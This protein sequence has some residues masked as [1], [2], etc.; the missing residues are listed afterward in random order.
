MLALSKL[1]RAHALK[2]VKVFIN[3]ALAVRTVL[4]RFSERAAGGSHCF[5][6]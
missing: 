5:G 1:T 4:S 3:G 6:I 2:Q